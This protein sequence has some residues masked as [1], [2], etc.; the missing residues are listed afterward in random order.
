MIAGILPV[1]MGLFFLGTA[2][3]VFLVIPTAMKFLL[4]FGSPVLRPMISIGEYLGF[5]FW[6]VVG[7]GVFFQLPLVIVTLA[8]FGVV[9]PKTL[10][11]YR[12]HAVVGIF[13]AAAAMTPGPDIVSQVAMALPSYLLFEVS[14]LIARRLYR[15]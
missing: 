10:A 9:N 14:L 7:F 1:A 8:R 13:I 11:Q 15:K 4:G 5:L 6:M 2:I 3:A 12:K